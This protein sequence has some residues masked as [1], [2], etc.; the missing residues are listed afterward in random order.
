MFIVKFQG[1]LGNQMF[2]YS[3]YRALERRFP[4]V[5]VMADLISYRT[6]D[7]HNGWELGKVFGIEVKEA[8]D[9]DIVRLSNRR[10][11]WKWKIAE[12]IRNKIKGRICSNEHTPAS[13]IY[14]NSGLLWELID[15]HNDYY[16]DGYWAH[17]FA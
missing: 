4:E 14:E 17:S 9:R 12:K 15:P 6:Y 16:F 3:L 5:D 10:L 1:G 2:Q 13:V 7:F 8:T 11:P